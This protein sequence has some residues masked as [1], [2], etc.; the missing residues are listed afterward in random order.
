MRTSLLS[1]RSLALIT[2]WIVSVD[3]KVV[4]WLTGVYAP[5]TCLVSLDSTT[6]AIPGDDPMCTLHD[7]PMLKVASSSSPRTPSTPRIR[8]PHLP[9]RRAG[10][11][12]PSAARRSTGLSSH[13]ARRTTTGGLPRGADDDANAPPGMGWS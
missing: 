2:A 11:A 4:V 12:T 3:A 7:A 9:A 1:F 10:D 6:L 13:G 5:L 8:S